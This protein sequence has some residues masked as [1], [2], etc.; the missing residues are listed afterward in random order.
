LEK[1]RGFGKAKTLSKIR[2]RS[3]LVKNNFMYKHIEETH[4]K[5]AASLILPAVINIVHPKSVVDVG[6]GTGSFLSVLKD[7]GF[8]DLLG[9]EGDWLDRSR[10]YVESEIVKTA[11][12]QKPF[13]H[14]RKFDLAICLEVAEHLEADSADTIV[15][16]LTGLSDVILFS[17]AIPGQGGQNH[18]NEQWSQYW[19]DKFKA[20]GYSFY[21]SVRMLFWN[22][23]NVD[24]WYKQ[25]MFLVIKDGTNNFG[26]A[27][28]LTPNDL[29]H[30]ELF[31]LIVHSYHQYIRLAWGEEP[32]GKYMRLLVKSILK[33]LGLVR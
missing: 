16:T 5:L 22:N 12:L 11:D 1:S 13:T 23:A 19:V 26:L 33:R 15:E 30:P 29:V 32:I 17:A 3:L 28:E 4:N 24:Y 7:L 31:N 21:D 6:C 20:R 2:K 8:T 18:I 25:N 9:V 14:H 10:L 27:K